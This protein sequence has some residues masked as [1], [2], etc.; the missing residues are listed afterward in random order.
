MVGTKRVEN[1]LVSG[2]V[3]VLPEESPDDEEN[4]GSEIDSY[5]DEMY[6]SEN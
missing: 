4:E 3:D 1:W 6:D 5:M 2:L